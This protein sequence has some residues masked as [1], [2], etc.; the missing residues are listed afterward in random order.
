LN[1]G[2]EEIPEHRINRHSNTYLI[3]FIGF[4][5]V[6]RRNIP[7]CYSPRNQ[8]EWRLKRSLTPNP[9]GNPRM[10]DKSPKANQKSKSQK[11][12]K[13]DN[14]NMQKQAASAAKQTAGGKK[15]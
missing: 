6:R 10:G 3:A 13:N 2:F 1:L 12:T 15:K 5:G 7:V 9:K 4:R 11:K 8:A 14:A